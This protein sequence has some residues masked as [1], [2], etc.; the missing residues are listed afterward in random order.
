LKKRFPSTHRS[1]T[2]T[3]AADHFPSPSLGLNGNRR[4]LPGYLQTSAEQAE[5]LAQLQTLNRQLSADNRQQSS[6]FH[7]RSSIFHLPSSIFDLPSP[8]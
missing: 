8:F 5:I 3:P 1:A 4:D 2:G 6:I 7:L